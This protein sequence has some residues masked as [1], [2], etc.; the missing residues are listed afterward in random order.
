MKIIVTPYNPDWPKF[1]DIEASKIKEALGANC[2]AIHHIGSTSIP[3]ISA[4]P[5]IDILPVVRNIQ[6]N[7]MQYVFFARAIF[8]NQKKIL[9]LGRLHI[10]I[11]SI[12]SF[13]KMLK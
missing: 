4:K 12:L 3:G 2:I 8:L 7:G 6:E 10:K 9:I 13:I 5:V 11:T 1:F